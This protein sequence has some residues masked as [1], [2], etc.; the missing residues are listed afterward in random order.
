MSLAELGDWSLKYG[1]LDAKPVYHAAGSGAGEIHIRLKVGDEGIVWI[2][3]GLKEAIFYVEPISQ[4]EKFDG[5]QFTPNPAI[6]KEWKNLRDTPAGDCR[7]LAGLNPEEMIFSIVSN[8]ENHAVS[9]TH[10]IT[11]PTRSKWHTT[12]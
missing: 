9:L 2:C 5:S 7:E 6:R 11:W 4:P 1:Y 12:G 3:G 8:N 10:A